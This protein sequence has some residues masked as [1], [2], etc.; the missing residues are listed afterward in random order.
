VERTKKTAAVVTVFL[1]LYFISTILNLGTGI[2]F[3]Y[4]ENNYYTQGPLYPLR[5]AVSYLPV[6]LLIG[7]IVTG[8]KNFKM[9]QVY[10][11][12]FFALL[13]GSGAALDLIV[14]AGSLA[15]PCFAAAVLY[16][17]FFIVQS[18][19]K[20]DNLTGIGNRASFNEFINKLAK[21]NTMRSWA[22]VMIDL[23]H[24]KEINDTLGHLEGDNALRDM[25]NI[26][27]NSIRHSDFAARYGGDEFIIAIKAETDITKV[28]K[29]LEDAIEA[30]NSKNLKPYKLQM[31]FGCDVFTTSSGKSIGEFLNHIDELMYKHKAERRQAANAMNRRVTDRQAVPGRGT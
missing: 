9:S 8:I 20:I 11:L 25:A 15:W 5:L 14:R 2:Y 31:S 27:K 1:F 7:Y 24:F 13:I 26:I 3:Y 29:R 28:M 22:I 4:A 16:I 18:D 6:P 17:Y 19:A 10:L 21:Q 23:D 12:I 30:H